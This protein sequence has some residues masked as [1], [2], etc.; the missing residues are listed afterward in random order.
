M[1]TFP[2][3][4]MVLYWCAC[5]LY[6][7]HCIFWNAYEAVFLALWLRLILLSD[8]DVAT[9]K[10][11]CCDMHVSFSRALCHLSKMKIDSVHNCTSCCSPAFTL[12]LRS[13][14]QWTVECTQKQSSP[15]CLFSV[16]L[17]SEMGVSIQQFYSVS[18]LNKD[19]IEYS[20]P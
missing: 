4:M 6:D 3:F 2:E 10:S 5:V 13:A 17:T 16:F 1:L 7:R 18:E 14:P 12:L 11:P 19:L 9:F 8:G 20:I 15:K